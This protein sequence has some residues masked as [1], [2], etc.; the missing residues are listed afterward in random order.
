MLKLPV[1]FNSVARQ[2]EKLQSILQLFTIHQAKFNNDNK[3]ILLSTYLEISHMQLVV[4]LCC[5]IFLHCFLFCMILLL[6]PPF[7]SAFYFFVAVALEIHASANKRG[8]NMLTLML[9]LTMPPCYLLF[10]RYLCVQSYGVA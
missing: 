10:G 9:G 6:W 3:W 7:L 5:L 4:V 8:R 1:I 2:S